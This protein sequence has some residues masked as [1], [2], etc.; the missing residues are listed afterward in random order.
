MTYE[1]GEIRA[2]S[3]NVAYG[4]WFY[5]RSSATLTA[6]KDFV[7]F[8]QNT[9]YSTVPQANPRFMCKLRST[10]TSSGLTFKD[11]R[12][13]FRDVNMFASD[14]AEPEFTFS[15]YGK[16][17][18]GPVNVELYL[19]KNFGTGGTASSAGGSLVPGA[20]W[21]VTTAGDY[22]TIEFKFGDNSGKTLPA[23]D[24]YVEL[25]L[26]FPVNAEFNID[27][28]DVILVEGK[29]ANPVYPEEPIYEVMANAIAGMLPRPASDG[30]DIG[31]PIVLGSNGLEYSS[32]EIGKITT[33]AYTYTATKGEKLCDGSM[34]ETTAIDDT[35]MIPY[36]RLQSKLWDDTAKVPKWGTGTDFVEA[37]NIDTQAGFLIKNNKFGTVTAA[38]DGAVPTGFS[39]A[40][41][42]G[43]PVHVAAASRYTWEVSLIGD[44]TT[45]GDGKIFLRMETLSI[46]AVTV[47]GT[48]L[49]GIIYDTFDT[50][51]HDASN[52]QVQLTIDAVATPTIMGATHVVVGGVFTLWYQVD[53]AGTAPAITGTEVKVNLSSTDNYQLIC[54][55]T[56]A[57]LTGGQVSWITATAA[58][59]I[60]QSSYFEFQT[61]ATTHKDFFV[62]YDK[63]SGGTEPNLPGKKAIKVDITAADTD[64]NV[65]AKTRNAINMMYFQIPDLRGAYLRMED[66]S[67]SK[68][69]ANALIQMWNNTLSIKPSDSAVG[70]Y[71]WDEFRE[72]N[73]QSQMQAQQSTG[74]GTE[75]KQR[76]HQ[77]EYIGRT[78]PEGG[79]ET[80][81]YSALIN[82]VIKY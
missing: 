3:T 71:M 76:I 19:I 66:L 2:A 14:N 72:H 60:T 8:V 54:V 68:I 64:S 70:G 18:T 56:R 1:V 12:I 24:D 77:P 80:R 6:G 29:V 34:F 61:T 59:A 21:S 79:P 9:G 27:V 78:K 33:T 11:L 81:P 4:N 45:A 55:K 25:G 31:L 41:A 75:N 10:D 53:G 73:H 38:A 32:A 28:T 7:T 58:S 57:A 67:S 16:A 74:E 5:T 20:Q 17:T 13:R 82:Y 39:F 44:T 51:E 69:P 15:F 52:A 37:F 50:S 35:D 48:G 30:S 26:R 65:A 36:S 22:Y 43:N 63:D 62:W 42:T 40:A 47:T 23:L 46:P 49:A